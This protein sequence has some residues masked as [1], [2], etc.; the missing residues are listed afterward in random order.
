MI[1]NYI[2]SHANLKNDK[3]DLSKEL[4]EYHQQLERVFIQY[5]QQFNE[6]NRLIGEYEMY[7]NKARQ[8]LK[9]M[10]ISSRS[11]STNER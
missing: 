3:G 5:I 8:T 4:I 10:Q 1:E 6:L 9:K 7:E 11:V 2:S